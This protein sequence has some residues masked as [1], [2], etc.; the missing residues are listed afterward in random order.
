MGHE[1]IFCIQRLLVT[2]SWCTHFDINST[3][4]T[5]HKQGYIQVAR[6]TNDAILC[7]PMLL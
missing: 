3:V 6:E 5:K 2:E 7:N 1:Y 4:M